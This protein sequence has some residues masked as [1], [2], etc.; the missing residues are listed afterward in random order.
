MSAAAAL[1][2]LAGALASA[3]LVDVAR[4]AAAGRGAR[5]RRRGGR[6]TAAGLTTL[7]RLGRG[8]GPAAGRADLEARLDA[9]GISAP[10]ADVLAV[11]AGLALVALAGCVP[12][13]PALP[14]R[15]WLVAPLAAPVAGFLAPDAWLRRCISA[16]AAAMEAEL[17][18]VLD[19]LRVAVAA[20]LPANRALGEVGRRHPGALAAELRRTAAELELGIPAP[21]AYA[22]LARRAPAAGIGALVAALE[23][24]ARHGAPLAGTLGAQ[25]AEARAARAA[26]AAERAAR[27]APKIQLVVALLLVPSVML[28][29]AAAVVP[30]L[31]G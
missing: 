6:V 1:A 26:R 22:R 9:A 7:R 18:D 23:R 30:A 21:A 5:P 3:G 31:L 28:L 15:L 12:L 29:V 25:A 16:R 20:G 19:L 4:L 14:G 24:A 13:A 2:A 11:K 27:A 8:L 17:A 10:A